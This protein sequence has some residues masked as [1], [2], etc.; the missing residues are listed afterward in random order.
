MKPLKK[1][2]GRHT[3]PGGIYTYIN[4][5]ICITPFNPLQPQTSHIWPGGTAR[6]ALI[7][8]KIME[9]IQEILF[10]EF[11]NWFFTVKF[12]E[13]SA[14]KSFSCLVVCLTQL[15]MHVTRFITTYSR[16]QKAGR[17]GCQPF[18]SGQTNAIT[19]TGNTPSFWVNYNGLHKGN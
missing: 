10:F 3:Q 11:Q 18:T 4:R 13:N 1:P 7:G 6:M 9:H 14:T 5:S 17:S 16:S 19:H 2:F 12:P 15:W 8:G